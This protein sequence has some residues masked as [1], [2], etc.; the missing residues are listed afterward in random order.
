[1]GPG[2]QKFHIICER[3]VGLFSLIQQVIANVPWAVKEDRVPVVY[4]RGEHM[5]L[6]PERLPR[7]THCLGV[8][9]QAVDSRVS[10]LGHSGADPE[11]DSCESAVPERCGRLPGGRVL[12]VAAFW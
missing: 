9:L 4:F 2:T 10:G 6:D 12:R 1:M 8:L 11:V 7:R 5:L 3:D